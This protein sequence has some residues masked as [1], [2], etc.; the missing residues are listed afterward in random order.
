[1]RFFYWTL[2]IFLFSACSVPVAAPEDEPILVIATDLTSPKDSVLFHSFEK[3]YGAKVEIRQM[4]ADSLRKIFRKDR[5]NSGIDIVIMHRLYD[6][7]KLTQQN[8][9]ETIELDELPEEN[10][11]NSQRTI[12]GIGIDPFVS[13]TKRDFKWDINIYD[14]LSKTMFINMLTTKSQAHFFAPFEQRMNRVKTFHRIEKILAKSVQPN[15]FNRDS[16]SVLLCAY[17]QYAN[18]SP[19]DSLWNDFTKVHYPNSKT[20]GVFYDLVSLGIVDQSSH[21]DLSIQFLNWISQK[22]TNKKFNEL[23]GYFPHSDHPQFSIY[24]RSPTRLMQYHT[25]IERMLKELD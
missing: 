3:K 6:M 20:S 21:Y 25:M 4:S 18:R 1:M 7:R 11:S 2:L 13:I 24:A 23:R 8:I 12:F 9:F 14:D 15:A 5:Y 10:I 16:A 19:E 17:S 22:S